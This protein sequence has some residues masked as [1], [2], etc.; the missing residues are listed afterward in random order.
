MRESAEEATTFR[1]G[2]CTD[3]AQPPM[4]ALGSERIKPKGEDC[5]RS[6]SLCHLAHCT[7]SAEKSARIESGTVDATSYSML[8]KGCEVLELDS[9]SNQARHHKVLVT[10]GR[11]VR[12]PP[13]H[14]IQ[15]H[16][17][18]WIAHTTMLARICQVEGTCNAGYSGAISHKV[19][20]RW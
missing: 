6:P 15:A 2:P 1:A 12:H 17:Q 5:N 7:H 3:N 19:T 18:Q 4:H 16:A 20:H 10:Q 13:V 14:T 11:S 8:Q 9:C